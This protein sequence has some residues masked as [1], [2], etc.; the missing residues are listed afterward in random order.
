MDSS[1]RFPIAEFII[2]MKSGSRESRQTAYLDLSCGTA[3]P[4]HEN[5]PATVHEVDECLLQEDRQPLPCTGPVLRLLQFREDSQ[6]LAGDSS[7]GSW[8][9]GSAVEMGRRAGDD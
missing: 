2:K 7:Y 5:E 1:D 8:I 4:H 6:D 3:Q 9:D